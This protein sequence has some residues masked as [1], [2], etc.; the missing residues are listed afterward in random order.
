[1][2]QISASEVS[3]LRKTTG[4]G[5][6]DCKKAL[7]EAEGDFDKAVEI[8]RKKGQAVASKRADR[9]TTEGAVLAKV[10]DTATVG[11]VVA[12]SCETDF[13]AKNEDFV[14]FTQSILDKALAEKPAA[15]LVREHRLYQADFLMRFYRFSPGDIPL[16]KD[17]TLS[18]IADPKM[19]W[20]QQHPGFFP[21]N[22]N[23][24]GY[25]QLLKVPGIGPRSAKKL[26]RLRQERRIASFQQLK[27][28][29][30]QIAKLS[31]FVCL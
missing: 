11:A 7:Q 21:I 31:G 29:R 14:K 1:M 19:V 10:N 4:A 9:E 26:V 16:D 23:T 28:Q 18:E 13:V 20:A 25:W 15:S 17:G 3:K 6:M 22:L 30:L 27:G 2:A 12:L 5:M 8:I 24:A